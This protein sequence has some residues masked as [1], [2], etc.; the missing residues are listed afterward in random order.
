MV[1]HGIHWKE[2]F[3]NMDEQQRRINKDLILREKLAIARTDMAVDRTLL[4]YI[5]TTLYFSIAGLTITNF[6]Q[7]AFRSWIDIFFWIAA[8]VVLALGIWRFRQQKRKL[9]ESRSHIGNY[10]LEWEDDEI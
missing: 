2:R 7:P 1:A 6:V 8:A 5:R 3:I 9:K 4:S 10:R